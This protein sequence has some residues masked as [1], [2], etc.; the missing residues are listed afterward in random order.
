M[1]AVQLDIV[2]NVVNTS[3]AHTFLADR[4][5]TNKV[6][7][8]QQTLAT[9]IMR[10]IDTYNQCGDAIYPNIVPCLWFHMFICVMIRYYKQLTCLTGSYNQRFNPKR[11]NQTSP[12][13]CN[14]LFGVRDEAYFACI[15][16][17]CTR[18]TKCICSNF[19]S[20]IK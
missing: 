19:E 8:T 9:Y 3:L 12:C 16:N 13:C 1:Y 7:R 2:L 18:V 20:R 15:T 11:P 14:P 6:S 5:N 4:N 10:N 17:K